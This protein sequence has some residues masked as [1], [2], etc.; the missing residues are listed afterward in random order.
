VTE[1]QSREAGHLAACFTAASLIEACVQPSPGLVSPGDQGAHTDMNLLSFMI[2]S[3][4][5]APYFLSFV[6]LGLR[7]GGQSPNELFRELRR[8][9]REAEES[10]MRAT[11]GVNT[12]R[13]Q[14][15]LLGLAAGMTGMCVAR[16]VRVPSRE[17][18][19]TVREAC[20]G[21]CD[22]EL[23][24]LR[25][26]EARTKGEQQYL[27]LG[28]TGARG[29]AEKGFPTVEHVGYPALEQGLRKGLCLNDAAV[30]ALISV[31]A[32]VVDTTVLGRLGTEGLVTLHKTSQSILDSGSVFT[33]RGR[34]MIWEAHTEFSRMRLSPG[35]AA[36]L[37]A[38]SLALHFVENGFPK[39]EV[40]LAPSLF[41]RRDKDVATGLLRT[42]GP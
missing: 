6:K 4:A 26:D 9:G 23:A 36:D 1:L 3:S 10:L 37:I 30:H 5:L 40:I 24:G 14:L 21:L 12:Q 42:D 27:T 31:M 29:E 11:G 28:V 33:G 15:F 22:R 25:S 2:G 20:A 18:Y 34:E 17:F 41:E 8:V 19:S 39:P 32:V 35:G 13:G 38:L 7:S 16:G